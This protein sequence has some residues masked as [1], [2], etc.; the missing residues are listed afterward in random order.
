MYIWAFVWN[1]IITCHSPFQKNHLTHG[2][3]APGIQVKDKAHLDQ[4][5]SVMTVLMA[6]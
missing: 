3:S 1:L 2:K 4:D 5:S 6:K